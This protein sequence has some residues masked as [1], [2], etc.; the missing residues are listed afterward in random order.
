M[1][2]TVEEKVEVKQEVTL[3]EAFALWK[4]VGKTTGK[5]Y[6]SGNASKECGELAG[7]ALVGF[8]NTNKENPKAP[9]IRI[10]VKDGDKTIEV[11]SL[12]ENISK[13]EKRYLTGM[14]NEKE[15]LVGF[16]SKE[17][18]TNKPDIRVYFKD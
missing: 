16:Y 3:K 15:K 4:N 14:T 8:Y 2:K 6:L 7:A 1:R 10:C 11:A 9:D 17:E 18:N 5:E 12:W 13:N